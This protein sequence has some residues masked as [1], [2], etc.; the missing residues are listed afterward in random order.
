MAAARQD[1]KTAQA[2]RWPTVSVTAGYSTA[3]N[4]AVQAG[5]LSQLGQR[6]GAS[7]GIGV[8]IPLFDRGATSLDAQRAQV[9]AD[10][11]RLALQTEQLQVAL[12]VR[13]AYL[14]WQSAQQKLAAAQA[15]G[16]AAQQALDASEQRYRVGASTLVELTQARNALVQAQSALVSA[17]YDLSRQRAAFAYAVGDITPAAPLG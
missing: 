12:D 6:Q 11:A 8:S 4:S 2:G 7:I 16:R 17:R 5:L 10:D 13:R 3:Y 1:V 14:D 15:Q 9:A